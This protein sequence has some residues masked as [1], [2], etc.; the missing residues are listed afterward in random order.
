M[1]VRYEPRPGFMTPGWK[2][3]EERE[4]PEAEGSSLLASG[5]FVEVKPKAAPKK[6]AADARP[7]ADAEEDS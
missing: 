1:I 4:V 5:N 7:E 3:N 6:K 2:A